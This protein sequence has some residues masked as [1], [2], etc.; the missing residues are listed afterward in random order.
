MVGG[1]STLATEF[2]Y[3]GATGIVDALAGQLRKFSVR[4]TVWSAGRV[5]N[6]TGDTADARCNLAALPSA[7]ASVS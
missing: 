4:A 2:A 7:T 5:A 3:T 6:K 1:C